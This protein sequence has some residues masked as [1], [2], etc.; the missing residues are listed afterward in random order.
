MLRQR[1]VVI[2]AGVNDYDVLRNGKWAGQVFRVGKRAWSWN[3]A[4]GCVVATRREACQR[5]RSVELGKQVEVQ[6]DGTTH[7]VL[8]GATT[9]ARTTGA[10]SKKVVSAWLADD[11]VTV[12]LTRRIHNNGTGAE[13]ASGRKCA[14][15]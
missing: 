10:V 1:E 3:G 6:W 13:Q 14:D 4:K 5:V 7:Q 8:S 15:R 9:L 2:R 12:V 11:S